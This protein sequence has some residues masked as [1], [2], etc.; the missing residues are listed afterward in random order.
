MNFKTRLPLIEVLPMTIMTK[1]QKISR[2]SQ[3]SDETSHAMFSSE[4]FCQST[5]PLSTGLYKLH[6]LQYCI[7][8]DTILN[9][10]SIESRK[11]QRN[12]KIFAGIE[13]LRQTG[14]TTRL[15]GFQDIV[16]T[17]M[18]TR[19]MITT[20]KRKNKILMRKFQTLTYLTVKKVLPR[21][22]E[23]LTQGAGI[24]S[25]FFVYPKRPISVFFVF[26]FDKRV[27]SVFLVFFTFHF[28]NIFLIVCLIYFSSQLVELEKE[29]HFNRQESVFTLNTIFH[30]T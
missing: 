26:V 9:R 15:N 18:I 7:C 20:M 8:K 1:I 24:I 12:T 3:I 16:V 25:E 5:F 2:I 30:I 10:K 29:F 19:I 6:I 23:Q 22:R 27:I 21:G 13:F 28:S 14:H 4:F 11:N 17:L